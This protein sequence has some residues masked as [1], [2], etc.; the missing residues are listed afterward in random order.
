MPDFF[1]DYQSPHS[2]KRCDSLSDNIKNFLSDQEKTWEL[3]RINYGLLDKVRTREFHFGHFNIK[4]QF[5]PSRIISSSARIDP[6]SIAARTCF[7][8]NEN[9]PGEQKKLDLGTD[10]FLLCN[11]YPIFREH[12]TIPTKI[13]VP[14]EIKDHF[15]NMLVLTKKLSDYTLFY[16]GPQCGASA[17]DHFHFQAGNKSFLPIERDYNHMK[18]ETVKPWYSDGEIT[19][20]G[21]NTYPGKFVSFESGHIASLLKAFDSVYSGLKNH[22]RKEHEPLM[23]ILSIYDNQSWRIII[24]P[25]DKHRPSHYYEKGNNNMLISPAA[26]DFGGLLILP[27]EEDFSKISKEDIINIFNQVS[28]SDRHFHELRSAVLRKMENRGEE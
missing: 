22:T 26:V 5:N 6:E 27:R 2:G 17:P 28:V 12:F 14:Q 4:A 21:I 9:L 13:H 18:D 10:F 1:H 15:R 7:L 20:W 24:F 11:P 19:I 16:N 3:L 23:N 25:R 8:C